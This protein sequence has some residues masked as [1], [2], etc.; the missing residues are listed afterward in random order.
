M[1]KDSNSKERFVSHGSDIGRA[2]VNKKGRAA[3]DRLNQSLKSTP[4]GKKK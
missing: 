1:A 3:L 4:S 2:K